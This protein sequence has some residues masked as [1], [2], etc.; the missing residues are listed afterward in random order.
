MN[1]LAHIYLSGENPRIR[2]GN[3]MGDGIRGKDYLHFHPDIQIGIRL[4]REIDT[5]TDFHPIFRQSK[6]R[7]VPYHNHFSGIIVDMF[8]DHFLATHWELYHHESL[9]IF[10]HK[11]Y[12]SLSEFHLEL[13]QKTKSIAPYLIKYNWLERYQSLTDLE[14]ILGQMDKRFSFPS[15]MKDSVE[16][17]HNNYEEFQNEFVKFFNELMIFSDAKREEISKE[18]YKK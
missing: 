15:N 7:L 4:H 9:G 12:N 13:N 17:L 5:F 16:L 6:H 3:F 10:A 1:Y 14:S 11:F 8:Y 18:I 2:I